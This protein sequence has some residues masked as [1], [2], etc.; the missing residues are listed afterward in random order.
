VQRNQG[1]LEQYQAQFVAMK[2]EVEQERSRFEVEMRKAEERT[3]QAEQRMERVVAHAKQMGERQQAKSMHANQPKIVN[4]IQ[5]EPSNPDKGDDDDNAMQVNQAETVGEAA[6]YRIEDEDEGD[7]N[8]EDDDMYGQESKYPIH[9][10]SVP[11][12]RKFRRPYGGQGPVLRASLP[13]NM[14]PPAEPSYSAIVSISS[15]CKNAQPTN[16]YP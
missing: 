14:T 13:R 4:S 8:D 12:P 7:E 6:A 9:H 3:K 2:A 10:Q 16:R 1:F 5:T 11:K 15:P